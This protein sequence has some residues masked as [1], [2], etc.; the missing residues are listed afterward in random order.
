M[1]VVL[2][3]FAI[4]VSVVLFLSLFTF[5]PSDSPVFV[6]TPSVLPDN[7]LNVFGSALATPFVLLYG[8]FA[9]LLLSFGVLVAGVN[10]L[11][12]RKIGNILVKTTL[13]FIAS[14]PK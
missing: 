14:I 10:I 1:R 11:L 13:F 8:K 5:N 12:G 4:A 3:Y 9:A 6:S 7:V 2:G